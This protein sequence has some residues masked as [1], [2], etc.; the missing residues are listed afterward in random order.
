MD[1]FVAAS[2][3]TSASA[4]ECGVILPTD[5][6]RTRRCLLLKMAFQAQGLV[7]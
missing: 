2:R 7:A 3:P 1:C 5:P 4:Q 6:D